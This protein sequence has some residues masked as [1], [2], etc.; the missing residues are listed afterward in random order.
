[1]YYEFLLFNKNVTSTLFKLT[2]LAIKLNSWSKKKYLVYRMSIV[3]LMVNFYLFC[4]WIGQN[5]WKF[6]ALSLNITQCI[7]NLWTR[8]LKVVL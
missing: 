5:N 7:L 2:K 6:F 8:T 1:M 4:Y 3:G